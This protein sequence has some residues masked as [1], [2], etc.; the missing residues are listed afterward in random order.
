MVLGIGLNV[1]ESE[2]AGLGVRMW[3]DFQS[4]AEN[5]EIPFVFRDRTQAARHK[6]G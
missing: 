4:G 5:N 2:K 3:A 1:I 6:L